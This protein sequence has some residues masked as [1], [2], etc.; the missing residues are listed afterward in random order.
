MIT[1]FKQFNEK[2]TPDDMKNAI[3]LNIEMGDA[4]KQN[5]NQL[6]QKAPLELQKNANL[7]IT[8]IQKQIDYLTQQKQN[9]NQEIINLENAQRDLMPNNLNDPNNSKNQKIFTDTQKAKIQNNRNILKALDDKI[10][11]LQGEISRNKEKYL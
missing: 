4:Q 1:K 2:L 10:K 8:D 7:K 6:N 3:D 9:I 5:P 11:L